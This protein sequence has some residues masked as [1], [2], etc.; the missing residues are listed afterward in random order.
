MIRTKKFERWYLPD[1]LPSIHSDRQANNKNTVV[2][3]LGKWI[4]G[5]ERGGGRE[6]DGRR[7]GKKAMDAKAPVGSMIFSET[8]R[9]LDVLVFRGCFASS[10]Y[11]ARRW[12]VTGNVKLNGQV[13]SLS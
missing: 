6:G 1:K 10:I 3:D 8:E 4:E 11:M 5:R 2:G 7:A 13:V 12:V 9:R